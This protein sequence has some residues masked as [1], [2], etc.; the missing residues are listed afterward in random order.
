MLRVI[1]SHTKAAKGYYASK[2]EYLAGGK[3]ELTGRW[4]GKGAALLGLSGEVDR[5][6]ADL[7]CDNVNP[8]TGMALTPRQKKNRTPGYDFN[9]HACKSVSLLFGLTGDPA[10]LDAFRSAVDATMRDIEAEIKTRIRIGGRSEDRTSGI[11]VW[12]EYT[13]LTARPVAGVIDPHLHSHAFVYNAVFDPEERRWKAGQFRD[14]KASAPR[15]QRDFHNRLAWNLSELGYPIAKTE[16]GWELAC[17][18]RATIVRFSR[19]SGQIADFAERHGVSDPAEKDGLGARTR[20]RKHP[21]TSMDELRQEWQARLTD[22]ER[23]GLA[24]T[25][26]RRCGTVAAVSGAGKMSAAELAA[27]SSGDARRRVE[28]S[29][30]PPGLADRQRR[31]PH[32]F[33]R[34]RR[35]HLTDDTFEH[36]SPPALPPPRGPAHGR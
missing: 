28:G 18:E 29:T 9:F 15:F 8:L 33:H 5:Q 10:I 25:T 22:R 4:G 26:A 1:Q 6:S 3:Q 12:A 23:A 2:A 14:L 7:L 17:I 11:T 31:H 27:V 19:R 30:L 34:H 24:I 32:P 16:R 21:D 13:H 36:A 20:G 35:P